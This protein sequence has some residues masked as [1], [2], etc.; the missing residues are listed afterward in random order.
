M[1]L[2]YV[3]NALANLLTGDDLTTAT[4][5]SA[6]NS[7]EVAICVIAMTWKRGELNFKQPRV[8]LLFCAVAAGPAALVS[9]ALA[10]AILSVLKG[11]DFSTVFGTW[12]AADALGL[13]A[14]TPIL[15]VVRARDVLGLF[16]PKALARAI[17]PLGIL[18]GTLALVFLQ[19][20]FPVLFLV[21]PALLY[22]AFALGLSGSAIAIVLTAGV[23]LWATVNGYGP[24]TLVHGSLREQ[25]VF[26]Q[27]FVAVGALQSL[28]VGALLAERNLLG[29]ALAQAPDFHY[30]KNTKGQFVS[31]NQ[32]VA[33]H[34]GF[35]TPDA[36]IGKTDFDIAPFER[37]TQLFADEQAVLA[38]GAPLVDREDLL[39]DSSGISHW[40]STSKVPLR[41]QNGDVIGL[42]G[43]TRDISEQKYLDEALRVSVVRRFGADGGAD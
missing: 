35:P 33:R 6:C 39:V 22:V 17:P 10:S 23:A 34:N 3:A 21:F 4:L 28:A 25:I 13:L 18:L 36:M 42:A 40:Y 20:S 37:A 2:G 15:M 9:A 38:S 16:R 12:Y 43:V 27:L 14:A 29:A 26:F 8:L 32:T 1:L 11:A 5:L 7:L 31:V 24:L 19:S 30:I 41:D